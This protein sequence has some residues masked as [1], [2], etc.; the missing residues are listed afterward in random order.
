MRGIGLVVNVLDHPFASAPVIVRFPARERPQNYT[1]I[2]EGFPFFLPTLFHVD[3]YPIEMIELQSLQMLDNDSEMPML[4]TIHFTIDEIELL[5]TILACLNDSLDWDFKK[6]N[7]LI[8]GVVL[9]NHDETIP[10]RVNEISKKLFQWYIH[11]L[12]N[13]D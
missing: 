10:L 5:Q 12:K 11:E 7:G 13:N 2:G 6:D 3:E 4:T 8:S 9:L 1:S